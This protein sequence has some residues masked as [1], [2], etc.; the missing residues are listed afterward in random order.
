VDQH[1]FEYSSDFNSFELNVRLAHRV[2]RDRMVAMPDGT[3]T[4]QLAS[5]G[6]PSF[7]AGLRYIGIEE[8]LLWQS[9]ENGS[10][11]PTGTYDVQTHNALVGLQFGG[12]YKWTTKT[13][14]A[15]AGGKAGAYINFADMR[16]QINGIGQPEN[17]LPTA[18]LTAYQYAT[19]LPNLQ[20]TP[21]FPAAANVFWNHED[22]QRGSVYAAFL[23]TEMF[24]QYNVNPNLS[25]RFAW[26]QFWINGLAMA[27]YQLTFEPARAKINIGG[28]VYFTGLSLT[29]QWVW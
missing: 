4:R 6:V 14:S 24:A 28:N 23:E 16:R 13:W 19:N 29:G 27:P 10:P 11:I 5:G 21:P 20:P 8:R 1:S 3:W 18:P 2:G 17:L 26:E 25:F 15:G 9:R 7:F 22:V 12:N